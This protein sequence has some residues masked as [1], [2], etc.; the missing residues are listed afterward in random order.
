MLRKTIGHA[1]TL[2]FQTKGIAIDGD[3]AK[4]AKGAQVI[5]APNMVVVFMREEYG[6]DAAKMIEREHLL[7]KIRAAV[8]QDT[9]AAVGLNPCGSA[10]PFVARVCRGAHLTATPHLRYARAGACS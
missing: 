4:N 9:F 5:D 10:E 2:V 1:L 3:F 8:D 6:A 7:T